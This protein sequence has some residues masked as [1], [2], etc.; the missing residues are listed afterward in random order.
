MRRLP[1]LQKKNAG[2]SFREIDFFLDFSIL[3][4]PMTLREQVEVVLNDTIRP[5]LLRHRGG[6]EVVSL[7]EDSGTL[8]VRMSGGCVGCPAA[9]LTL[10]GGVEMELRERVPGINH[11]TAVTEAEKNE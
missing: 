10:K 11:V 7:D 1:R 6:L 8:Y 5:A 9:E 4:R 3:K 2:H